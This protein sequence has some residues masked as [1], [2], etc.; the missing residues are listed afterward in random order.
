VHH[1]FL[2]MGFLR[3]SPKVVPPRVTR[4]RCLPPRSPTALDL[5]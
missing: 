1:R 3:P 2:K 5:C 4:A